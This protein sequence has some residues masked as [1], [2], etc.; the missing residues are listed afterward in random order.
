MA[1]P[2]RPGAANL[3]SGPKWWTKPALISV[4][5][6]AVVLIVVTFLVGWSTPVLAVVIAGFAL[7]SW[8]FLDQRPGRH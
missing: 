3:S 7:G 8:W 6:V 5:N 1:I 4:L 2:D